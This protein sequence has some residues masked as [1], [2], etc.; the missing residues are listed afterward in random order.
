MVYATGCSN[1]E[2]PG[3]A[4]GDY[5]HATWVRYQW[6]AGAATRFSKSESP[7]ATDPAA[8]TDEDY[9]AFARSLAKNRV[10]TL[11]VFVGSLG[12]NGALP[13]WPIERREALGESGPLPIARL[14]TALAEE[15]VA[16][17]R[18][19]AW[20]GGRHEGYDRGFIDLSKPAI[21]QAVAAHAARLT[22]PEIGFDGIHL[23]IE[24]TLEGDENLLATLDAVRTAIPAKAL[25][26]FAGTMVLPYVAKLPRLRNRFW[27]ES[28][29]EEVATRVDQIAFM[30]YDTS[31]SSPRL[32]RWFLRRQAA[33]LVEGTHAANP[34]CEVY[35]GVPSYREESP[36]HASAAENVENATKALAMAARAMGPERA[37]LRGVAIYAA[38][39]TN[40]DDWALIRKAFP[41]GADES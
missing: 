12:E 19:L 33:L 39:T 28:Y 6:F 27:T 9:R 23:N 11:F 10:D 22:G 7:Y 17:A 1:G 29:L 18:L 14:R 5:R 38:W 24:P 37:S 31:I 20:L 8:L 41:P 35:L 4:P 15:G 34:E 21:R 30:T 2:T 25:L 13:L 36:H 40:E 3:A 26:S 16:D 32:F